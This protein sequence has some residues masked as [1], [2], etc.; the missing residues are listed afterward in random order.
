MLTLIWVFAVLRSPEKWV[1]LES[2]ELKPLLSLF[3]G[4]P[5]RNP[6]GI[7]LK[8]MFFGHVPLDAYIVYH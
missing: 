4:I 2:T 6:I 8:H 7:P 5:K 1:K 3:L